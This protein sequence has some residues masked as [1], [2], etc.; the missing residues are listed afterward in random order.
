M[1]AIFAVVC[2]FIVKGM[3]GFANTLVFSTIM[4]F[5]ANNINI[6][7]LELLIGYPSNIYIAWK[8]RKGISAKVCIPLSVLVIMG[9]MPGILFLKNGNTGFIKI[10]FGFAVIL[11]GFEMLLRE[12][13]KGKKK[14][15]KLA[16]AAIGFISGVLCGLFGIG[17]F[18]VAYIGRTTDN[19]AQFKGNI[20]I[21]FFVEN[22]VRIILYSLTGILNI[23]ILY[24][25]VLLMPYMVIG[26]AIGIFLSKKTSEIFVK[27]AVIILLILSGIS[28]IINNL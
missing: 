2:A 18:L 19:Q 1:I 24:K 20:C 23:G 26:L 13:L 25:A 5:N 11:I 8:E 27:N 14:N 3:C 12:R 4:S 15:S 7:P 22:T 10:L 6:T 21:V 17:A 9:I 16:L 28:L